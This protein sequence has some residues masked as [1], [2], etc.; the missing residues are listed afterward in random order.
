MH[1]VIHLP[2]DINAKYRA[3]VM[4][5]VLLLR[6]VPTWNAIGMKRVL[7]L[8]IDIYIGFVLHFA[9]P[10][11]CFPYMIPC[12]YH[13]INGIL[14]RNYKILLYLYVMILESEKYDNETK[15]MFNYQ[16]RDTSHNKITRG[17]FIWL[18]KCTIQTNL[19]I[20]YLNSSRQVI[21]NYVE[22]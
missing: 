16:I 8:I 3:L 9:D 22:I 14:T 11:I 6:V 17:N 21:V 19:C 2:P 18:K 5:R 4:T 7:A 1:V 13:H 10:F 20:F 12:M 15:N